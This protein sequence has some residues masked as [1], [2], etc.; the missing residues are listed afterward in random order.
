MCHFENDKGEIVRIFD[1]RGQE[2]TPGCKVRW[3]GVSER[4]P[5]IGRKIR[6]RGC[7]S[8]DSS[9]ANDGQ[10]ASCFPSRRATSRRGDGWWLF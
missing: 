4:R 9:P 7:S 6:S 2:L 10:G 8:A 3:P 5:R 1:S